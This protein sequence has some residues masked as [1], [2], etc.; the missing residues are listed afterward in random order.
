MVSVSSFIVSVINFQSSHFSGKSGNF[1]IGQKVGNFW[2]KIK[3]K[4]KILGL[5]VGTAE[6]A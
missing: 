1:R 5:W 6:E 2:E 4:L 3:V